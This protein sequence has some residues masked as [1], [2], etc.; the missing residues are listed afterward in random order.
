MWDELGILPTSNRGE[1]RRAY[2][3]CL[4]ALDL[5]REP[6]AFQRLRA[7]YE[8]AL[9]LAKG[10]CAQQSARAPAAPFV[11]VS[12]TRSEVR[13]ETDDTS[14]LEAETVAAVEDALARGHVAEAA[15][16][17]QRAWAAGI[18]RLPADEPLLERMVDAAIDPAADPTTFRT[19][20]ALADG[21]VLRPGAVLHHSERQRKVAARLEGESWYEG[22]LATADGRAPGTPRRARRSA[23]YLLGRGWR[24][25]L[26]HKEEDDFDALLAAY[27]TQCPSIGHRIAPSWIAALKRRVAGSRRRGTIYL[28][29]FF[30]L[31]VLTQI[32]GVGFNFGGV[33]DP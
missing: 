22:I 17:Y 10:E 15:A 31:V 9:D 27:A 13:G 26:S 29:V 18:L 6:E 21:T 20:L 23:R 3:I 8:E 11:Y 12:E 25:W 30:I 24:L 2:A 5:D 32:W 33:F 4:K 1:I 19:V 28:V 16:L 14:R 7:A